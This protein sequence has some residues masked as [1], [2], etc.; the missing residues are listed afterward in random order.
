MKQL[1]FPQ[2]RL[3]LFVLLAAAATGCKSSK[4]A[5][6][7]PPYDYPPS[8]LPIPPEPPIADE[9]SQGRAALL[10]R[11][12]EP[13]PLLQPDSAALSQ[14]EAKGKLIQ[15][16]QQLPD[17]LRN[18]INVGQPKCLDSKTACYVDVTYPDWNTFIKVNRAVIDIQPASPFMS[19]P[20]PRY[21]TGRVLVEK[22]GKKFLSTW[23]L[24]NQLRPPE[25][26][27]EPSPWREKQ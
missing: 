24:A 2:W 1:L 18:Q 22:G 8:E 13:L 12:S 26:R 27:R 5:Q 16:F 19:F 4:A 9:E 6:G 20:G 21:R 11:F 25:Q 23:I 7:A 17:A 15:T 10:A 3:G 14:L